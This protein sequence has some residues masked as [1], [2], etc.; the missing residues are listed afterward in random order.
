MRDLFHLHAG[1]AYG[2][3]L[4][5]KVWGSGFRVWGLGFRV[6]GYEGVVEGKLLIK[7]SRLTT[8]GS[9]HCMRNPR[10]RTFRVCK[11]GDYSQNDSIGP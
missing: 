9:R 4:E 1:V 8:K 10:V 2:S 5:A 11:A 6:E 7:G 3:L